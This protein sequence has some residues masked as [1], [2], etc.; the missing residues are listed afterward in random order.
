MNDDSNDFSVKATL[1]ED[2]ITGLWYKKRKKNPSEI[3]CRVPRLPGFS[4][5][6]LFHSDNT[7]TKHN[8]SIGSRRRKHPGAWQGGSNTEGVLREYSEYLRRSKGDLKEYYES[9]ES[10]L[11][12]YIR[13]TK[14]ERK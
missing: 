14:G 6:A 7:E 2:F 1:Q 10:V 4:A 11:K 13:N 12:E 9:T 3:P 5:V 8:I